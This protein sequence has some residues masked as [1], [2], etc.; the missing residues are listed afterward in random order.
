M[1]F[2]VFLKKFIEETFRLMS[3]RVCDEIFIDHACV[4]SIVT[5]VLNNKNKTK[6]D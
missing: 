1:L 3:M 6:R 2:N 4:D 5:V